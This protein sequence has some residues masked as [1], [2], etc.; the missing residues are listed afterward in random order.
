VFTDAGF[1]RLV[2]QP[3]S[4]ELKSYLVNVGF[5]STQSELCLSLKG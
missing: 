4:P 5:E 2:A 1:D 3:T